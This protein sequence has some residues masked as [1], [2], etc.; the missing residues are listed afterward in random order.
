MGMQ[1]SAANVENNLE[2]PQK[3]EFLYDPRSSTWRYAS[4]LQAGTQT[5]KW[6]LMFAAALFK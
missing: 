5:D 2:I 4:E 6:Y 3:V 1:N